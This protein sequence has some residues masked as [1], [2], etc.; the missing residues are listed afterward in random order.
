M[1]NK[2]FKI[3]IAL[4]FK[5]LFFLSIF[6]VILFGYFSKNVDAASLYLS[7]QNSSV[8]V[9]GTLNVSL[10]LDTDDKAVNVIESELFFPPDK[11]QLA[12]P[13]FGESIIQIWP[14][15][16]LFSNSEGRVY[17]IGGKPSPGITTKNGTVLTLTFKVVSAGSGEIRFGKKSSVLANDGAGTDVLNSKT[18][19]SFNAT[20]P[21]SFGPKIFS[22]THP[23]QDKWF[24]NSNPLFYWNRSSISEDFSF[25]LDHDPKGMPDIIP[26]GGGATST[27]YSGIEN[28]IWY[29]HLIEKIGGVWGGAS[30]YAIKVDSD[31]P[32]AF[33]IY[34]TPSKETISQS[35]VF[36]FSTNDSF[37]GIDHYEMKI[38]PLSLSEKEGVIFFRVS[39]PYQAINWK[40]GRYL[41]VVRAIDNAGNVRDE[42][43]TVSSLN[44]FS[45]FISQEGV[46]LIVGVVPWIWIIFAGIIIL[47]IFLIMFVRLWLEHREH[48]THAFLEDIKKFLKLIRNKD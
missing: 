48:L 22:P 21:P 35:P 20:F 33:T 32:D 42:S 16:P 10:V 28:G 11:L 39:S 34:T 31:K 45:K 13:S 44:L 25:K 15:P 37:S 18:T 24:S 43:V 3:K 26:D 29:F 12:A 4:I 38:V 46:D 8:L 5:K 47:L 14:T 7:P 40:V 1:E 27:S 41:I 23:N 17:L 6:I 36:R 19:A 9:G 30:H 2:K